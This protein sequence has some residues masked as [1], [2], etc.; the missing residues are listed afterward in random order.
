LEKKHKTVKVGVVQATPAL[1]NIEKTVEIVID[2]IEKAA[3]EGCK[4]LL[5]PESFIP[6]YPR[7]VRFDAIVG[8]RT[9]KSRDQWLDY[10]SNSLEIPSAF[11]D[12]ISV[13]IKKAQIFV[14]LGVTEKESL[15]G[16]L[17]CALLY[18]DTKGELIGKH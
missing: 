13:A 12:R 18:F 8:K 11:F 17:H 4:L 1:F 9:D 16:S 10:W 14:A 15:G 5:F 7:G 3:K 2:W 6:C